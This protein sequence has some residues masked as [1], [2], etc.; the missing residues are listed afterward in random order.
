MSGL[1]RMNHGNGVLQ[2]LQTPRDGH[3][4][5]EVHTRRVESAVRIGSQRDGN[6]KD[7]QCRMLTGMAW[8]KESTSRIRNITE[9]HGADYCGRERGKWRILTLPSTPRGG[10]RMQWHG[11]AETL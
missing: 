11:M 6:R 9:S 7:A 3:M 10:K 5:S 8:D 2:G 4:Y 1:T